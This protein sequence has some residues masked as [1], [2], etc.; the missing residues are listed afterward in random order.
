MIAFMAAIAEAQAE[1]TKQVQRVG[2]DNALENKTKYVG[3]MPSY[4]RS[5][6]KAITAMIDCSIGDS[7]IAKETG[8]SRQT[9]IRIKK[10]PAGADAALRRWGM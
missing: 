5:T 10:D 6:I 2:I 4:D 9:V 8:V 1:A 7:E 3:R